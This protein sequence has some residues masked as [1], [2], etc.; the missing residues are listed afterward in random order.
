MV[1][2]LALLTDSSVSVL[3]ARS[4]HVS[5]TDIVLDPVPSVALG[6]GKNTANRVNDI[7]HTTLNVLQSTP[8]LYQ[9]VPSE[10]DITPR[11]GDR[12]GAVL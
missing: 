3:Q 2:Q 11:V 4:E 12:F 10:A 5:Y 6:A 7:I 9:D 8:L 1:P